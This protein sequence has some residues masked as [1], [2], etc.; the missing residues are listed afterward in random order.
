[1]PSGAGHFTLYCSYYIIKNLDAMN[2]SDTFFI[3]AL[4][5]LG[6]YQPFLSLSLLLGKLFTLL[7]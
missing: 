2:S 3:R 7:L 1:M 5:I 6:K 4:G